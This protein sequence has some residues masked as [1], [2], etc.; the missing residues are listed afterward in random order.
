MSKNISKIRSPEQLHL[1][2]EAV[3]RDLVQAN[4]YYRLFRDVNNAVAEYTRE[5]NQSRVFWSLTRDALLDAARL[6]LCRVYEREKDKNANSLGY[7]LAAIK[8][9]LHMFEFEPF[10]ERLKSNEYIDPY[11]SWK[12]LDEAQLDA[13]ILFA[14]ESNSAVR[15]LVFWRDKQFVHRDSTHIIRKIRIGKEKLPTYGDIGSLLDNGLTIANRYSAL[16]NQHTWGRTMV[17]HDDY[18]FVLKLIRDGLKLRRERLNAELKG[19]GIDN[20]GE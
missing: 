10:Q 1:V 14:T 17:G 7:L 15:R 9:N 20:P 18:A 6:R 2:I 16:F 13:D 5:M 4:C 12:K 19:H 3:Q 11:E 8:H